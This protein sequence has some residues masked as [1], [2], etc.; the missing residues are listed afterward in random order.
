MK[1]TAVIAVILILSCGYAVETAFVK[2]ASVD[3]T[4]P[5]PEL[6][7]GWFYGATQSTLGTNLNQSSPGSLQWAS[8]DIDSS[9]FS[10][11]ANSHQ[12]TIN[13]AGNY[14]AAYTLPFSST[15]QRAAIHSE[16]RVNGI[17]IP[18][19][20][21][22]SSFI[23]A[24]S[25]HNESSNHVAVLLS[26]LSVGD[27]IDLTVQLGGEI[28]VV[29]MYDSGSL[30]L[31]Y[32]GSSRDIFSATAT[33]GTSGTN[34]NQAAHSLQW[35]SD[36]K[37]GEFTHSNGSHQ[38]TVATGGIYQLH[39]NVPLNSAGDRTNIK[40]KV[41]VN[42]TMVDGGDAK[43]GYIRADSDHFDAS[44][45]WS[46]LIHG[47][48]AGDIISI[49]VEQEA[50]PDPVTVQTGDAASIFIERIGAN[51][52]LFSARATALSG[53]NDWS[54]A[55]SQTILWQ[56]QNTIDSSVFSHST[57]VNA[58]EITINRSGDFLLMYNDSLSSTAQRASTRISVRLNGTEI[59][60]A[61]SMSHYIRNGSA[62]NESSTSIVFL[63]NNVSA[64]D[65]VSLTA[66]EEG[67]AATMDDVEDAILSI[68]LREE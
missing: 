66:V 32:I 49:S 44:V 68:W 63:L 6:L 26:N 55:P 24:M 30:Y 17:P 54:P 61:Q 67:L 48:S 1:W 16:I 52:G 33:A 34:F 46:G 9:A 51:T 7:V 28:G 50:D 20:T 40:A 15:V 41:L 23:R 29:D 58:D 22:E 11:T 38:I 36:V 18:G 53:G 13:R 21:S 14:F 2:S 12:I 8:N 59:N 10:H 19:T 60:G 43:Q 65:I 39:L 64:G 5:E 25:N 3:N 56:T 35:T 27:I 45:H 42:G 37:T 62:H 31:E 4:P 57:T 47:L